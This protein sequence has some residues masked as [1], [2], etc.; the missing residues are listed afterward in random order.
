MK[1]DLTNV[2]LELKFILDILNENDDFISYPINIERSIDW[3]KFV[4]LVI[5]HRI[6]PQVFTKL[7]Q[8]KLQSL[9]PE[10]VF[11]KLNNSY[12]TN[13]LKMLYLSREM[14]RICRVFNDDDVR[15]LVLK[16]PVLAESL[17]GDISLRTSSDLDLLVPINELDKVGSL[18]A[19][20]GYLKD[21]YITSV[22]GEWKWRHH[23]VTYFHP[24][25]KVKIEVHWRLSP[26][27]GAEPDFNDL[28]K[29]KR[30]SIL[31]TTPIYFLGQEDLFLFL[32]S[33]GSRHGWS[34]LRWLVDIHQLV[35]QDV[36]WRYLLSLLQKYQLHQLSGKTLIL[37]C[38]LL[39]TEIN[40]DMLSLVTQKSKELGQKTVFYFEHMIN[41]HAE[42]LDDYVSKYHQNYLFSLKTIPQKLLFIISFLYPYPEDVSTLK[43]PKNL[44]VLYFVL[45]P[46]LWC[47][48]KTKRRYSLNRGI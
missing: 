21:D 25:K 9:V 22:L 29:R 19:N 20:E 39:G 34:R 16:G 23:H 46:F 6:Y 44:H 4:S 41:L 2:P 37:T 31:T 8:N 43:L 26:G 5:H 18:L 27:P 48:R 14:D 30:R 33:H 1:L 17:Y 45:R 40:K 36:D 32:V 3:G 47:W 35:G 38:N 24:E 12:K 11:H 10:H 7:K 15:M 42:T 13:T 28:W